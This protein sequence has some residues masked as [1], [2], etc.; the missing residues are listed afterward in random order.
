MDDIIFQ[1]S[2]PNSVYVLNSNYRYYGNFA[3]LNLIEPN[4][5][6]SKNQS[7]CQHAALTSSG[8][9]SCSAATRP[10][11]HKLRHFGK[12]CD[13][14]E[15]IGNPVTTAPTTTINPPA[16]TCLASTDAFQKF[17][18]RSYVANTGGCDSLHSL[19]TDCYCGR[20]AGA[21]TDTNSMQNICKNKPNNNNKK[22]NINLKPSLIAKKTK[23]RKFIEEEKWKTGDECILENEYQ[24]NHNV[25]VEFTGSSTPTEFRTNSSVKESNT[26]ESTTLTASMAAM[27]T[28]GPLNNIVK[29][30]WNGKMEPNATG[31]E[32]KKHQ[33][34][35]QSNNWSGSGDS[36]NQQHQAPQQLEVLK[37]THQ[38]KTNYEL[39]KE[40]SDLLG[41]P[42]T[43][44]DN[45]RCLECQS[46]YFD[47]DDSDSLSEV[48]NSDEYDEDTTNVL[49]NSVELVMYANCY[50]DNTMTGN[51]ISTIQQ[52]QQQK[53]SSC[54]QERR[55][56]NFT[57]P[58]VNCNA[59]E[60]G[61]VDQDSYNLVARGG[62]EAANGIERIDIVNQNVLH[63]VQ[64][65]ELENCS[66]FNGLSLSDVNTEMPLDT[67]SESRG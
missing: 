52:R 43:L 54:S 45:C 60:F 37:S 30:Y 57:C 29:H 39:Y 17:F 63:S 53:W 3:R 28:C 10:T 12:F 44:C 66:S 23:F 7:Y 41:L 47:C 25:R 59:R 16:P 27:A 6:I 22:K 67:G 38:Q 21:C 50:S 65:N 42:C 33:Q 40:A 24:N 61:G 56:P 18:N 35:N 5:V 26:A 55:Q 14:P 62:D 19:H 34:Q 46:S 49:N 8:H 48:S 9:R 11:Q 4:D 31:S 32:R 13:V 64:S 15:A 2:N 20:A 51:G 58:D 36:N 1:S